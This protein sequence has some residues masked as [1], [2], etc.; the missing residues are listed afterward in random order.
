MVPEWARGARAKGF[1]VAVYGPAL[2]SV[3]VWIRNKDWRGVRSPV[4]YCSVCC[5]VIQI[6]VIERTRDWELSFD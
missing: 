6:L 3:P 1:Q 2:F 5:T 4:D